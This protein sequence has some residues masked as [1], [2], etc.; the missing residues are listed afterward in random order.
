MRLVPVNCIK[1][2]S[3][4]SKSIY[5]TK[6]RVLL[7]KGVSL[8]P[9]ILQRVRCHGF[10]S[11]YIQDEYS[12]EEIEDVIRPELRQKAI[13]TVKNYFGFFKHPLEVS[14]NTPK[15]DDDASRREYLQSLRD[16]AE[17]IVEEILEQKNVLINLVDIKSMDNYTY[18]HCV[19]VA[20]LSL[21]MGIELG[22]NRKQLMDLAVGAMLHDVGKIFIPT[23]VLNKKGKLDDREFQLIKEHPEKGYEYLKDIY[24]ISSLSRAIVIQ[25][26]EKVDGSGYPRGLKNN[27]IHSY[28]KLVAIADVYDALTSDRPYRRGLSPNEALEYIMGAV[29]KEFDYTIVKAFMRKIVPYPVGALV[30]LSNGCIAAVVENNHYLP[31]RPVVRVILGDSQ[32]AKDD[33]IDL[34]RNYSI[35]IDGIQ[36]EDP[37]EENRE[38]A[39]GM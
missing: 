32:Y 39:F 23:E 5:D 30:K 19:N 33:I 27:E 18:A 8:T 7:A 26:H 9:L 24:E 34:Y 25:H 38:K 12:E 20:I 15:K 6:G 28:A 4:L 35:V 22:F 36:Y 29:D 37:L 2:G 31:M 11:L 17:S 21:V 3:Y 16:I 10:L 14:I 13:F 1:S